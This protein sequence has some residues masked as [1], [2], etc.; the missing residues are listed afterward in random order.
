MYTISVLS[1]LTFLARSDLI[2]FSLLVESLSPTDRDRSVEPKGLSSLLSNTLPSI[3]TVVVSTGDLG[4]FTVS[5]IRPLN[6]RLMKNKKIINQQ[7]FQD[8]EH[9]V[10]SL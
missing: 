5:S 6:D 3:V 7:S 9:V 2:R 1:D 10:W 4:W 8:N